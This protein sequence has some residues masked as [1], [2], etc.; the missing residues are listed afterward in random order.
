MPASLIGL[1]LLIVEDNYLVASLI[2]EIFAAAGCIVSEP[3][4]Q[5]VQAQD[6]ARR[7]DYDAAVL[8]INL[9]GEAAYPVADILSYR[10]IPYLF[11]TGYSAQHIKYC[12]R[13]KLGKPFKSAQLLD[14][15]SNLVS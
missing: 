11:L 9:N 4:P 6:A 5:L 14:A 15:V 2:Q 10:N 1:K 8:D 3:I 12:E 7:G 13:P